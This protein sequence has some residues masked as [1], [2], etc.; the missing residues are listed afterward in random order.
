MIYNQKLKITLEEDFIKV[1]TYLGLKIKNT[2]QK[3]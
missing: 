2:S 1:G 3:V